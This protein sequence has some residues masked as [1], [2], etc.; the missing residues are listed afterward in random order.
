QGALVALVTRVPEGTGR[1]QRG[2]VHVV[3]LDVRVEVN[4]RTGGAVLRAVVRARLDR[5]VWGRAAVDCPQNVGGLLAA[6]AVASDPLGSLLQ[7]GQHA[8]QLLELPT[9]E[10]APNGQRDRLM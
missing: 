9:G 10:K 1:R 7:A 2:Q 5:D 8:V 3:L 4:P 6:D